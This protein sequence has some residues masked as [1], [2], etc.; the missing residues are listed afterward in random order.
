MST[1][2]TTREEK[3]KEFYKTLKSEIDLPYFADKDHENFED[4]RDAIENGNGF[5]IEII[6]YSNAIE[7][8][9][10][11]D[12]SLRESLAIADECGFEVKNLSSETLAS[13]LASRN[14]RDEFDELESEITEFFEQL[15]EERDAEEETEEEEEEN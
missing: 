13:L 14:A 2:V 12:N 15:N 9:K 7:Y 8:L 3:M 10:E 1:T 6:Y 5:D 11:N 4:L